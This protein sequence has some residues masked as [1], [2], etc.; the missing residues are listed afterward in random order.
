A[1]A[2]TVAVVAAYRP[3]QPAVPGPPPR[4]DLEVGEAFARAA[5]HGGEHV[6]KLADTALSSFERT[7]NPLGLAAVDT[8][9]RLEA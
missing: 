9:I 6:I 1:W 7:G 4:G 2:A 3:A 5:A 8:A